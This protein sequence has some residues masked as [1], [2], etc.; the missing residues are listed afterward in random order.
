MRWS[1]LEFSNEL[2]AFYK[3]NHA[4]NWN[5][6]RDGL[7]IFHSPGQNFVYADIEGNIGY[8][9]GVKLPKRKSNS[10]SFVYDGTTRSK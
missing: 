8:T 2:T 4:H 7:E 3:I 1:A 6:F 5:E 10:P 9:A